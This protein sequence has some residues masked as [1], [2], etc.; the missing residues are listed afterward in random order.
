MKPKDPKAFWHSKLS[1]FQ[2]CPRKYEMQYVKNIP[3]PEYPKSA[4]LSY[5]SA[6]HMGLEMSFNGYDVDAIIGAFELYWDTL[7]DEKMTYDRHN[8]AQMRDMGAIHLSK[9]MRYQRKHIEPIV[10]EERQYSKLGPHAFEGTP[11]V[12]GKYK[13]VLSVIDFKT[14]GYRYDKKKAYN[15]YQLLG[16]DYLLTQNGHPPAEQVIYIVFVKQTGGLQVIHAPITPEMRKD[17][18]DSMGCLLD[19]MKDTK[20]YPKNPQSCMFGKHLCPY[21]EMCWNTPPKKS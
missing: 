5:G 2:S 3:H 9:F 8:W 10:F 20:C 6:I 11:D 18:L 19:T 17:Y 12:Y 4:A 1:V 7:K 13:G 15:A 16:Y 14:A 21:F